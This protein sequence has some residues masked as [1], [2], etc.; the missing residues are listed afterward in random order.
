M[1]FSDACGVMVSYL[2]L[3]TVV[4]VGIGMATLASLFVAINLLWLLMIFASLLKRYLLILAIHLFGMAD[5][6]PGVICLGGQLQLG[7]TML[8]FAA[9]Q[10]SI[11]LTQLLPI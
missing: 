3:T 6:R 10:M 2:A 5:S 7:G 4:A 8:G 9:G 1:R 11:A